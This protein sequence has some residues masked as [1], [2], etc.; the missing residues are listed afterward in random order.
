MTKEAQIPFNAIK[1][2]SDDFTNRYV[3]WK[4]GYRHSVFRPRGEN[5]LIN[6]P[7]GNIS[8]RKLR[9]AHKFLKEVFNHHDKPYWVNVTL[10][11]PKQLPNCSKTIRSC[12]RS[13][14]K[15]K[16]KLAS[17]Y[18]VATEAGIKNNRYHHHVFIYAGSFAS[19]CKAEAKLQKL[20]GEIL[21]E[22]F[23]NIFEEC[24]LSDAFDTAHI[25]KDCDEK[26]AFNAENYYRKQLR[27]EAYD[28]IRSPFSNKNPDIHTSNY[29]Q[30][31][32]QERNNSIENYS[33]LAWSVRP[34]FKEY[35]DE[36]WL[37]EAF[38]HLSYICKKANP[39]LP[40][41]RLTL[42]STKRCK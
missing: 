24:E 38:Y 40:E 9:T 21:F 15:R 23:S 34:P 25:Y 8:E 29:S 2:I 30:D 28:A 4:G 1:S 10:N 22:R 17:H 36:E 33:T 26:E 31:Y 32:Y 35:K 19:V 39:L 18:I 3:N 13:L 5:L 42:Y 16:N 11:Y 6:N 12:M 7:Y 37:K 41:K 27:K 20:W 14:M